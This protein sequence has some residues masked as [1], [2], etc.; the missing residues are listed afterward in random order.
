M[1]LVGMLKTPARFFVFEPVAVTADVDRGR[2][3][4][5]A[6]ELAVNPRVRRL[7]IEPA[8][9]RPMPVVRN[10]PPVLPPCWALV[11]DIGRYADCRFLLDGVHQQRSQA[12]CSSQSSR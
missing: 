10:I 2:V 8:G 3:M 12:E 1:V 5:Q 6:V 7:H 4:E 9:A 11:L